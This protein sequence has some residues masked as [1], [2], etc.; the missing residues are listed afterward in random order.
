MSTEFSCK[1]SLNMILPALK[2]VALVLGF[3]YATSVVATPAQLPLLTRSSTPAVP[4]VMFTLDD[5]GSMAWRYMPDSIGP[6]GNQ[7]WEWV[8][9]PGDNPG[10]S[11]T[12]R[13]ITTRAAA[14][15]AGT[16]LMSA[17]MRS[18]AYNTIYY[19]PEIRYQPWYNSDGS[20]LPN[21][22]PRAAW[23]NP[24]N[25][26]DVS[27]AAARTTAVNNGRAVRL[28]NEDG[29]GEITYTTSQ[30]WCKSRNDGTA[31]STAVDNGT[32]LNCHNI[33]GERFAP[34][35]YYVHNGG[36]FTTAANFTRVRIAIDLPATDIPRGA[37]RTDCVQSG[38]GRSCTR[39]QELQNFANWF[40]YYRTRLFL[41]IAATSRSFSEQG[42]ELRVGYGLINQPATVVDGVSTRTVV[43][44]VRNFQGADR[45]AFFNWLHSAP[46]NGGTPL[47][48]AMD[49]VGQY[50]SRADNRGPW[51]NTPGTDDGVAAT[52]HLQCRRS[53]HILMTDG[54]WNGD[55]ASTAAARGNVDGSNGPTITGPGNQSYSYSPAAPYSDGHS[56]TLA[57]V[58]MYYWNRDL[59]PDL[60]N[61]I[62]PSD[63]NPAFWQHMVN[64]TVG[65]GLTGTRNFP[66]DWPALQAGSLGWPAPVADGPTTLDDLWHAAVNSRGRYLSARD[67]V[68]FSNALSSILAEINDA[69]ASEGGVATAGA[70][71]EAGNRKYVPVYRT[72]DWTGNLTAYNLD[73][74]GQQLTAA[75]NAEQSLPAHGSRNIVAGTR[76]E[77]P[78]A[79]P[80]TWAGLTAAMRAEM[81]AGAS[82][83]LVNYL[84]GDASQE[85]STYR[86]RS[87]RLG[88]F[89]NSQ[90]VFVKG[91]VD[92]QYNFLPVGTPGRGDYRSFV[93]AKRERNGVVFIGGNAGMLHGFADTPGVNAT[94]QPAGREVFAFIPRALLPG[95]S[96]LASNSYG[97]RYYVDGP[98]T[99]SDAYWSGAWRN[100]LVGTTG[101]GTPSVFALDVTNPTAM[102]A[103]NVL[104]EFDRTVDPELGHVMAPVQ[105]GLMKNGQWAAVFGNGPFSAAGRAQLFVINLQTGQLIR[106]IDTGVGGANGL[107]GVRLI[108]DANR[109]VVGAYAG[110]LRGNVWKFDL[111]NTNATAWGVAFGGQPLY[112]AVDASNNPQPI[113]AAP[114]Y[115]IH[116]RGGYMVLVG[117]GKLYE[118]G[119]ESSSQPQS[120]YGLWDK[121]QLIQGTGG[122]WVWSNDA[123]QGPITLPSSIV[124]QNFSSTT[125]AG[126]GGATFYLVNST[127]LDWSQHRGWSLPLTIVGGHRNL[128]TPQMVLGGF[129]LF[130][131]MSPYSDQPPDPCDAV[132]SGVGFNLLI[133]PLNG[134]MPTEPVFDTN[135]D[136]VVDS[137]DEVVSGYRTEAD[138][139]DSLLY[140][141][142]TPSTP[143]C[144]PGTPGCD[145]DEPPCA[146]PGKRLFSI[147]GTSGSTLGCLSTG[148]AQRSWRQLFQFPQ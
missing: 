122:G 132:N 71:L 73:A 94:T 68:E 3:A 121:Q 41:S 2:G 128:V 76:N 127:T 1:A 30:L 119:D 117:T 95:L 148:A 29:T 65:L 59:R 140:D 80:F 15:N 82:E 49:D 17:R 114:E 47:R 87:A 38:T 90:P 101:A 11:Y 36:N 18:S 51:G 53:Y 100:V 25:R 13:P 42:T 143:T 103:S 16:D 147:Q 12:A 124:Q 14:N 33:T 58:A 129:A 4:N 35:T 110:D 10:G 28:I 91:L 8:F 125:I 107:G 134:A 52:S 85:G 102:G 74:N 78:R 31:N 118:E 131:T 43:R 106:R 112:T 7:R 144:T 141:R 105:V 96:A 9:H 5:S 97:H 69:E 98:L 86:R 88:D 77:A 62:R 55:A 145:E 57:D 6:T 26:V 50:F 19:N 22:N 67:P 21:A 40:T 44:G 93:A 133:N 32:A 70:A 46:A 99:E 60:P 24:N 72:G 45:T 137:R 27:T 120:L 54:Y 39:E 23:T 79:V 104:W 75:W 84:R 34:A 37:G 81:G 56:N 126:A 123:A 92:M 108:R 61:R 111:S 116:P 64:F 63:T 48:R 113:V 20:Q 66:G 115:V 89:V 139:R 146:Q 135:G 83:A 138:G 130:E 142:T 109:V 136:G